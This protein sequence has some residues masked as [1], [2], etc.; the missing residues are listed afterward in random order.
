MIEADGTPVNKILGTLLVG[1]MLTVC[2]SIARAGP[3]EDGFSAQQR[4]DYTSALRLWRPL[5]EQGNA[6]AQGLLGFMY[7]QGQGSYAR[8]LVTA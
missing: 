8:K 7:Q 6:V 1:L 2:G 3:L 5:A 4:G